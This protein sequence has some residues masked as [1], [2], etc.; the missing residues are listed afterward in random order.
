MKYVPYVFFLLLYP[1]QSYSQNSPLEGFLDGKSVVLVSTAPAAK[2]I[3]PWDSLATEVHSALVEA[4]GDP[5]AYYELETVTLSEATQ[6]SF[7]AQFAKRLIRNVVV[8]TRK[9]N[10]ELFIH[11]MPFTQDKNIVAPGTA[12]SASAGDLEA[13][14]NVIAEAGR[15]RHSQNLLVI[16]VPEFGQ[17]AGEAG[18]AA[19][20]QRFLARNPLN[21]DV[22][23]LGV[24]LS[25]AAGEWGFLSTFRYDLLGKSPEQV[26][27]EQKSEMEGLQKIFETHYP[28]EVV[29]LGTP[30]S[31]EALIKERIQFVLM[32]IE[33]READLMKNMG[34][35][36]PE[37]I[38]PDRIVVKYYIKLLVRDE[39]YL[40]PVWDADPDWNTAL[41]NFLNNLKI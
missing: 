34:L 31:D 4:G 24:P 13:F 16:E 2:P 10:A 12:W 27:A 7:A 23:K 20:N 41:V 1:V 9:E 11:I 25:G 35:E 30:Q 32:R 5:V 3:I 22:F 37:N 15:N 21:L 39:M 33:G 36:L 29:F 14:K 6:Q 28:Y 8:I 18:T 40:G 19:G 17:N 38:D 26:M